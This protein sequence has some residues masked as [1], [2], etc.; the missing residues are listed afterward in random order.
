MC[1]C[2][3]GLLR[4]SSSSFLNV[5]DN[6]QML[7]KLGKKHRLLPAVPLWPAEP[8]GRPPRS[9]RFCCWGI[10]RDLARLSSASLAESDSPHSHRTVEEE[11][12]VLQEREG[13]GRILKDA[14]SQCGLHFWKGFTK[15]LSFFASSF[16]DEANTGP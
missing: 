7:Q 10:L 2:V 14:L 1:L 11:E 4:M 16:A 3:K 9:S 5:P 6:E 13:S 12:V 8:P 15:N